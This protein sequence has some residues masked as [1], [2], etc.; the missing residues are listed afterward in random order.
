MSSLIP[1]INYA[2]SATTYTITGLSFF[3]AVISIIEWFSPGR[4]AWFGDVKTLHV[5]AVYAFLAIYLLD[6]LALEVFT[7]LE[8]EEIP[9]VGYYLD[10]DF[11]G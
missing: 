11:P 9:E 7:L 10:W 8:E 1:L 4:F 5:F 6:W 2:F 3:V